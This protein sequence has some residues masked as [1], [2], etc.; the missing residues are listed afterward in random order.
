M[1]VLSNIRRLFVSEK[2]LKDLKPSRLMYW[3]HVN[4]DLYIQI[5][6]IQMCSLSMRRLT[7]PRRVRNSNFAFWRVDVDTHLASGLR[8][9]VMFG[10]LLLFQFDC[11]GRRYSLRSV[12]ILTCAA[13]KVSVSRRP[14]S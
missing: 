14:V 1:R 8:S 2:R 9:G 4:A 6:G 5:S 13:D 10:S 3:R 11:V 7:I 12:D